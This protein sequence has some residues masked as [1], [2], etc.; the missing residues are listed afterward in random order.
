M[1]T[2]VDQSTE[3]ARVAREY[4]AALGRGESDAPQRFYAPDGLGHIHGVF[5][6]APPEASVAFFT[7]LFEAFPDWDFEVLDVVTEG[8]RAAVR[9]RAR[10]TFA[11]PGTFMGFEP[12]GARADVEGTDFVWVRDGKMVRLEAYMNGAELARQL[13]AL[14]AQG[15][16]A[17][18]RLAKA[19]NVRTRVKRR[20]V[21]DPE[22]VA[23]GVWVVRG[24]FPGK[25][26]NIYLVRDGEGV[27]L[28]DAGIKAMT[29]AIAAIG[30]TLG[31]ITRVLL[32]HGHVD[33]RGVAPYLGVPVLCHPNN[34]ADAEG[35]GGMDYFDLSKLPPH[36]RPIYPRLLRMWDG[37]PVA[38]AGTVEEGDEI[39]G[40]EVVDLSGHAPGLIG[41]WRA[42]DR[43]ALTTDCFYTVDPFTGRHGPPRVP[44]A[45]F[46]Y[47][48]EQARASIR[49][50]A[51]MEP[52]SAWPGHADPLTGDVRGQL[53]EA[54]ATT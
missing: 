8:E 24:G 3:T 13:G 11:G 50:L 42:S 39:A 51:A 2:D 40:F 49:K 22:P 32:G 14:P 7:E 28:F 17:E 19:F 38:I 45:A 43:L 53:E 18:E 37:G 33:H 44:P 29:D 31:G 52:A 48:T 5:G 54:A 4:F 35:E 26:M 34:R 21:S 12:N 36:A 20:F 23:D 25:A 41:L 46:T 1:A 6:P 27:M 9:W 47:D 30:A 10:G 16:A 15:S